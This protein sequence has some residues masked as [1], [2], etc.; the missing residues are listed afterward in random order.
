MSVNNE[1]P[2]GEYERQSA[3]NGCVKRLDRT[4]K[5]SEARKYREGTECV[6]IAVMRI[7]ILSNIN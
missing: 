6:W 4:V 5:G 1:K 2:D 7:N 3:S